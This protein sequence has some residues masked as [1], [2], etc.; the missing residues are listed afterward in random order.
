MDWLDKDFIISS[1][2]NNVNRIKSMQQTE[3][4]SQHVTNL[5]A[6][7]Y[8]LLI[9]IKKKNLTIQLGKSTNGLYRKFAGKVHLA[10]K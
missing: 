8:K 1:C 3:K 5:I 10:N 9:Q 6:L 7:I 4:Y 2:G